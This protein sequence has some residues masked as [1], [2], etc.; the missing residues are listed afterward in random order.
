MVS[1]ADFAG[2]LCSR[3][4]HD[5]LSPVGAMANG[6][7]LLADEQDETARAQVMELLAESARASASKLKFFR[8]AF[9]AAGGF[10]DVVDSRDVEAAARGLY[11]RERRIE[12]DWLVD[13]PTLGKAAVKALLNLIM[14]A[15]DALP[16]GGHL[17]AGAE[18][19]GAATE[20]VVRAEGPRLT[21]DPAL[22]EAL[23]GRAPS[24]GLNPRV[25]GAWLVHLLAA[26]H[27]GHAQV[28][29][30]DDGVLLFGATLG[31][32]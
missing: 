21:L 32:A 24:D 1:A 23:A 17:T 28:M 30:S 11:G 2:L 26:E 6:V 12:F 19:H 27:G 20:L 3:L 15:G 18:T 14:L 22:S 9:G 16:R 10:G 4:C 29:R 5:L 8:L 13:T 31:A 7:E 25:A